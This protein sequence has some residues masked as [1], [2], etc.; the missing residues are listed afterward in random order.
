MQRV[1]SKYNI[2]ILRKLGEGKRASFYV[3][4]S[5]YHGKPRLILLNVNERTG[6][7]GGIYSLPLELAPK[8]FSNLGRILKELKGRG[9]ER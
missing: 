7:V 3:G 4:T 9:G 6:W 8:L 2:K 5:E 1:K